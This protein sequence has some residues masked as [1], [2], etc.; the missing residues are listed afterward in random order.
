MRTGGMSA[1][2]GIKWWIMMGIPWNMM[3]IS[4]IGYIE[5]IIPFPLIGT[6]MIPS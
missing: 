2:H 1:N 6:I 3:A 4:E 5:E